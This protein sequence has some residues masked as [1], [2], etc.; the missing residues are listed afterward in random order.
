[1]RRK[2]AIFLG[3]TGILILA[4]TFSGR[5]SLPRQESPKPPNDK[6]SL[7]EYLPQHPLTPSPNHPLSQM[8]DMVDQVSEAAARNEWHT[9]A[10]S[11]ERLEEAWERG[12]FKQ[13]RKLEIE[14]EITDSIQSL[15][16]HVWAQNKKGTL[17]AAQ[18]LTELISRLLTD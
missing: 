1:M 8:Q 9:A 18:N 6:V 10:R 3:L 15:R 14:T 4:L 11:V 7:T 12:M 2:I 17:Q 16:R 5:L 13:E